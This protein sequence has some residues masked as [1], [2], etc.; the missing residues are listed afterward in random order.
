MTA[1]LETVVPRFTTVLIVLQQLSF[2]IFVKTKPQ[3]FG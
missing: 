1:V 3:T 2:F